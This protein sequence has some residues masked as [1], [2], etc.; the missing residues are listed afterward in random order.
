MRR[1]LAA[2]LRSLAR[3]TLPSARLLVGRWYVAIILAPLLWPAF[4]AFRLLVAWRT[5]DF[6]PYEAQ[7]RLIGLPMTVLA[8]LLGVRV[9]AGE[10]DR[11]TLE[12]AYT[13]PGGTHRV[14]VAKLVAAL[15][16]LLASEL[17]LAA[18]ALVF[19]DYPPG[20]LYGALQRRRSSGAR[21]AAPSWPSRS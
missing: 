9:I 2:R 4:E 10:I 7:V 20:A 16:I 8:I 3:L 11:R 14:W 17:L 12:I 5:E 13:V 18:A 21:P 6:A 19:T 15:A 1:R